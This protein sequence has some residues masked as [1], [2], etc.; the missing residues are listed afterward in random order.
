MFGTNF[1]ARGSIDDDMT[2]PN[3]N[4]EL[5]PKYN[6]FS[7]NSFRQCHLTYFENIFLPALKKPRNCDNY[8]DFFE[9]KTIEE[10]HIRRRPYTSYFYGWLDLC[11]LLLDRGICRKT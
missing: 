10:G 9:A 6:S 7:L 8:T 1:G 11:K 4:F 3:V 2:P 5:V